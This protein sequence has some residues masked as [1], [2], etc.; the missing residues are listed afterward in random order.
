M[1]IKSVPVEKVRIDG[2]TQIRKSLNQ[3]AVSEYAEIL[4]DK[5]GK[6]LP[7]V[8]VVFDG[9]E[10][11][12]WDGFHRW[13]AHNQ[14]GIGMIQVEIEN[15]TQRDAILK[16]CGANSAHGLKRTNADKRNAVETLLNDTEWVKWS[17]NKIAEEACVSVQ[18]VANIRSELSKIDNSPAAKSAGQPKKGRDGKMYPP[19]PPKKKPTPEASP[20]QQVSDFFNGKESVQEKAEEKPPKQKVMRAD[21]DMPES[22]VD[23]NGDEV[24]RSLWGVW[25]QKTAL[26]QI[27]NDL[28]VVHGKLAKYNETEASCSFSVAAEDLVHD[29]IGKAGD[30]IPS[31]VDEGSWLAA[32]ECEDG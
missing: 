22:Y 6:G 23:D 3:D 9:S 21:A 2:G 24:P 30:A 18:T 29:A 14:A 31:V 8:S 17:D 5:D 32:G 20:K 12:L 27:R 15:G 26:Y 28:Q 25:R 19:K 16:A 1:S 4:Q 13:H 11:W 10:Y 7:P